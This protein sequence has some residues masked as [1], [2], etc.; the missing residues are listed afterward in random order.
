VVL[1]LV[2]A[3]VYLPVVHAGFLHD[4][5]ELLTANPIVQRGGWGAEAWSGLRELWVPRPGALTRFNL[6]GIPVTATALWLEWRLWGDGAPGYHVVN[7]LLHV[8]CALLLWQVLARL[9]VPGAWWAAL[10]WAVHPVCVESVAWISELKNTLSMVFLLASLS[11]WLRWCETGARAPWWRSLLGFLLALLSK[12]TAV[13]F[14]LALLLIGWWKRRPLAAELRAALPFFALACASGL[15]A[16]YTQSTLAI[17]EEPIAAGSLLERIYRAN[18]ALGFYVWKALLPF[19]LVAVYP[20][21]HETL[22]W[23][24]QLLPGLLAAG[25]LVASWHARETWGRPVIVGFGGFAL[26]LA[27][28]LGLVPMSYMRHTLVADH[29]Q[30]QALPFLIAAIVGSAVAAR[31]RWASRAPCVTAAAALAVVLAWHTVSYAKMFHDR[32]TLWSHVLERNPGSWAAQDQRGLKLMSEGR[33]RAALEHF[34]RAVA[35]APDRTE[36]RNNLAVLLDRMGLRDR[37]LEQIEKAAELS[38]GNGAVRINCAMGLLAAGRSAE[39]LPHFAAALPLLP[40]D[41]AIHVSYG[42]ALLDAGRPRL[43]I[44]QL[45][46]ALA[47]DPNRPRARMLLAAAQSQLGQ[48]AGGG[49]AAAASH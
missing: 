26:M 27:P 3:A 18:F 32:G 35:L 5:D 34:E 40:P 16:V 12:P 19:D 33:P 24:V 8:V 13:P 10:L 1:L 23:F 43:A 38:P 14:P 6:P 30:Y 29:F 47:L 22:P 25:L 45:Q 37:A 31:P 39:A 17:G 11:A 4:D 20:R 48:A 21:W 49:S 7:V 36:V 9:A 41:P 28:V 44:E 15:F 2:A 46:R 42:A